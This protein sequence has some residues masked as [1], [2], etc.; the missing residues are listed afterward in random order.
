MA[1]LAAK[2]MPQSGSGIRR[3][4][5]EA[6]LIDLQEKAQ[7]P[8]TVSQRFHSLHQF[9]KWPAMGGLSGQFL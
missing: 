4:C 8:A 3:E 2:G 7:R 5:V 6:S 1:I 9:F